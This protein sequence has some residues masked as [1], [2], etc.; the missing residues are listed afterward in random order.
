M[1]RESRIVAFPP[2]NVSQFVDSIIQVTLK[3]LYVRMENL[4]CQIILCE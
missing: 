4:I 3:Y 1:N 2:S